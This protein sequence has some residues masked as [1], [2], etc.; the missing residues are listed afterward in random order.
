MSY[1]MLTLGALTTSFIYQKK[2]F[3]VHAYQRMKVYLYIKT[4]LV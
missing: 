1:T 4:S 3:H 2:I